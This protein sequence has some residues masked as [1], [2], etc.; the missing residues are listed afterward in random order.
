[1]TITIDELIA[2]DILECI[3]IVELIYMTRLSRDTHLSYI[4]DNFHNI[5]SQL[6]SSFRPGRTCL[7]LQFIAD[8][9]LYC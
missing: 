4:K 6:L 3:A 1:M 2:F 9:K 7:S 5:S 8:F